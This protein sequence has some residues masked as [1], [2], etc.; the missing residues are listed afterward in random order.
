MLS[1]ENTFTGPFVLQDKK[2]HFAQTVFAEPMESPGAET[3]EDSESEDDQQLEPC[4]PQFLKFNE[5]RQSVNHVDSASLGIRIFK[6]P[7]YILFCSLKTFLAE[8]H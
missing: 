5:V 6:V 3:P 2:P 4:T 7:L 1:K 8:Q